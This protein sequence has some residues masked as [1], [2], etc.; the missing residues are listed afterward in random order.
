MDETCSAFFVCVGLPVIGAA[1]L[2]IK[3]QEGGVRFR[4]LRKGVSERR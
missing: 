3:L 4:V 2:C 1:R